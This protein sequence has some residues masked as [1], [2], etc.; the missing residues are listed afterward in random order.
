M[1]DQA[2]RVVRSG[3]VTT[4]FLRRPAR[5]NAVD[6]GTERGNQVA[7]EGDAPMGAPCGCPG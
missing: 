7:P 5:R 3:L 6:G 1:T 4:V 2:V